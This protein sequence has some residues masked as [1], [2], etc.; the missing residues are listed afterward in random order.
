MWAENRQ[1]RDRTFVSVL[2]RHR[3][4]ST[5]TRAL[6]AVGLGLAAVLLWFG[7]SVF[8][9]DCGPVESAA[10]V[11]VLALPAVVETVVD[12]GLTDD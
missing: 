1:R 9:F 8:P 7:L 5:E 3:Y 10:S 4:M 12:G 11:G 6:L 2:V